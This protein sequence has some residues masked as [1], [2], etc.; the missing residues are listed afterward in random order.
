MKPEVKNQ[1]KE[2][3]QKKGVADMRPTKH[4][5]EEMGTTPKVWT[6]WLKKTANPGFEQVPTIASFL[7]CEIQDLFPDEFRGLSKNN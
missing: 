2:V 1:I 3:L 4:Q 6:K 7:G 5:M